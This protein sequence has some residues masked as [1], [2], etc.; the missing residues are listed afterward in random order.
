MKK[1]TLAEQLACLLKKIRFLIVSLL[2][3]MSIFTFN[4]CK[5]VSEVSNVLIDP[6][7]N[8][9]LEMS[10]DSMGQIFY[11]L[12][13]SAGDTLMDK[14]MIGFH[15]HSGSL[16]AGFNRAMATEV[17]IGQLYY[18]SV[19]KEKEVYLQ[20]YTERSWIYHHSTGVELL[21]QARLLADG[22]TFRIGLKSPKGE[23]IFI[24]EELTYFGID[25]GAKSWITPY[26][27]VTKWTPGYEL[28]F[29]ESKG[30][31][32]APGKEGWAFPALFEYR[33]NYLLMTESFLDGTYPASHFEFDTSFNQ[34]K[35]RYPEASEANGLWDSY[36]QPFET[37]MT[38]WRVIIISNSLEDLTNVKLVDALNPDPAI[39]DWSWVF[40]GRSSWSWWSDHDSPQ[41]IQKLKSFIDFSAEMD[42]EYSLIDANWNLIDSDSVQSVINYAAEK[43]VG[44]WMWYNSG[45]PHNEV[46]EAPRDR[47][48]LRLDR[49]EE[50]AKLYEWGVKGIKIDFFQSDKWPII[51]QYIDILEDAAEFK[52]MVNFHGCTLPRGW[53]KTYPHLLTMEAVRGAEAYSFNEAF[54]AIAPAH[55]CILPFTRNV[56]GPMDYTPVT[57]SMQKYNRHTT[58]LHELALAVVFESYIQHLAD[59]PSSYW[60]QPKLVF[61]YLSKIP[62]SWSESR[63]L[64][65]SIGKSVVMARKQDMEWFI[66]GING[67]SFYKTITI[68]L[69]FLDQINGEIQVLVE[70]GEG[71]ILE[72]IYDLGAYTAIEI[73]IQGNGGFVAWIRLQD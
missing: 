28:P 69:S 16:V 43:K 66:A 31:T 35:I 23:N 62:A 40:P 25:C 48:H 27:E 20:S 68:D 50:F 10:L 42:W 33:D 64:H 70:S 19:F 58:T 22:L 12:R 14:S 65:A 57:F 52:L 49:R 5:Q 46:E 29:I 47:M 71:E 30:C 8:Y 60:A 63:C 34:Y 4:S 21:F 18:Q 67:E 39:V 45:G 56:V 11:S 53:S 13:T 55:H 24:K 7:N 6:T 32:N 26:D 2:L 61:D 51:K 9:I 36:P 54:P 15:L 41:D 3:G 59:S 73:P 38:P 1:N 17:E 72:Y 44:I 37:I